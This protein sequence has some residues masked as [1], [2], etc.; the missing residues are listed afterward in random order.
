MNETPRTAQGF[1]APAAAAR[2]VELIFGKGG[3][4]DAVTNLS[5]A[6]IVENNLFLASDEGAFVERL[7]FSGGAWR[8]HVRIA[9]GELLKLKDEDAEADLEGLAVSDGWLWVIGSHA[10]TRPKAEKAE[11]E[12]IDLDKLA[13]LKDTR[14]RCLFARLPLVRSADGWLPVKRDGIRRA[15]LLKQGK[16]G[17]GLSKFLKQ[18]PL[19]RP[20]TDIPAK[21][22]GV[23]VEGIAVLGDR[24]ALGMRGPVIGGHA[25]LL[26]VQ[27]EGKQSGKLHLAGEPVFRMLA[28]EGLGIRDLDLDGGD[29]LILA[30]PTT[31]LSG[32]CALYRWRDW[33]NDAPRDARKVRLHRPE[34]SL[35]LPFGDGFDH[36]EGISVWR[37]SGSG[38]GQL[39]V[40]CD[41]PGEQ[42]LNERTG[43]ILADIFDLRLQPE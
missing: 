33:A 35:E 39:L 21:E 12:C 31:A 5:A 24:V 17:N 4:I 13:D 16:Q 6:A 15:G 42:R 1:P 20:F 2:S 14:P 22:G 25:L 29:L 19:L 38:A 7:T 32:P 41:S 23:D 37:E 8:N 34:R 26:E 43:T 11:D 40:A 30:G 27:L 28:L 3:D 36:P 10:R 9:L 18:S